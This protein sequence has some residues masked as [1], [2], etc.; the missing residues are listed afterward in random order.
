MRQKNGIPFYARK[1][2]QKNTEGFK[3]K[4]PLKFEPHFAAEK[5]WCKQ[6]NNCTA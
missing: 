6:A 4:P 3:R 2:S 5:T 1:S